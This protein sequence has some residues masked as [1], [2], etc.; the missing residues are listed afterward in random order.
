MVVDGSF[1]G[2]LQWTV[3]FAG[4][5]HT[6]TAKMLDPLY[7]LELNSEKRA[8]AG[9]DIAA[10]AKNV[11]VNRAPSVD[12]VNPF[13]APDANTS[14]TAKVAT[15]LAINGHVEDDGLPRGSKIGSEWR[16]ITGP[17]EVTFSNTATAATRVKFG[18]PGAY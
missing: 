10:A 11:C 1:K 5:T 14:L 16:K 4:K 12:L 2:P 3:R 13:G 6:T 7:E 17:G 8:T 9:L 18:A 15:D